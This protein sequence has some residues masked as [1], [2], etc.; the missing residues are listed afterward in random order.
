MLAIFF[1]FFQHLKENN[2]NGE[3]ASFFSS[4]QAGI[5]ETIDYV[6]KLYDPATQLQLVS[7]VFVTGGCANIPGKC[8][9][10]FQL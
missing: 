3:F 9:L 4:H 5:S 2:R 10:H 1:F 6:V 7:N 8:T